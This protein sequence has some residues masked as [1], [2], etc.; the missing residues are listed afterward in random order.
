MILSD[1]T[2]PDKMIYQSS[3]KKV[4]FLDITLH[5]YDATG[6]TL[7]NL[8][9][10]WPKDNLLMIGSAERVLLSQAEGYI[11]TFALGNDELKHLF[12]L[13]L[14]KSV[15]RSRKRIWTTDSLNINKTTEF[16][17]EKHTNK[18]LSIFP[19]I[20]NH[21][22]SL[23]YSLGLNH[24]FF[25][26]NVSAKMDKWIKE[27]DPDFFYAVLSTRHS[28]LFAMEIVKKFKKPLIIHIMDDWPATIGSNTF[29]HKLWN[30]KINKE[31]KELFKHAD[32]RIAISKL[33]AE[34]YE[35]RFGGRWI[36]FH[37]P[38]AFNNW[39]KHQK[40]VVA[41]L[42]NPVKVGYFGRV[43]RANAQSI[44]LFV[45]AINSH[46]VEYTIEF[47][48]FTSNTI[49][50]QNAK[51]VYFHSFIDNSLMPAT[52][53]SFDLLLLP[54]SFID[55]DFLFA[56]YS[57][58]TKLSEYLISGVPVIVIAPK[59]IALTEFVSTRNCG[60]C[61]CT[62]NLAEI[63]KRINHFISDTNLQSIYSENGK[64]IASSE[65]EI[66]NVV[67]KFNEVFEEK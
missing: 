3:I 46:Q 55:E 5:R 28:I 58:P 24:F 50:D 4:L 62:T 48:L 41:P 9:S 31:L 39:E 54:I 57:I 38:V 6:I 45:E 67:T 15:Y 37:N 59:G 11:N 43:G 17:S 22:K 23:F 49:N 64:T 56:Q 25:R 47:H 21:F 63:T 13:G 14:I 26:C 16:K 27:L 8:F 18:K 29:T 10:R 2:K 51:N 66:N 19:T 35:K 61:I 52:I 33:M 36:Y 42:M 65:F 12:P 7:S 40:K 32:T 60:L 30:K 1:I 53:T 44:D 20:L 34:E